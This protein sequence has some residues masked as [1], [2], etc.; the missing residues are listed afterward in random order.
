VAA[1]TLTMPQVGFL[2]VLT[3]FAGAVGLGARVTSTI[4]NGIISVDRF[5]ENGGCD[6]LG[7][8]SSTCEG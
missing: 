4:K 1:K 7:P 5:R 6:G 8:C 3:E 2:S